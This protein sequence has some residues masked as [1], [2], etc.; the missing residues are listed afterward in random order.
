MGAP[1]CGKT[2]EEIYPYTEKREKRVSIV[3]ENKNQSKERASPTE[4][5]PPP[6]FGKGEQGGI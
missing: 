6:P 4:K 5:I 2:Q 1:A 3:N